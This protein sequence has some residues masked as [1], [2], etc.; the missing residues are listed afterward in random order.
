[1]KIVE[2][3]YISVFVASVGIIIAILTTNDVSVSGYTPQIIKNFGAVYALIL[4]TALTPPAD[5]L[6]R[7]CPSFNLIGVEC[8]VTWWGVAVI[9]AG[10]TSVAY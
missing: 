4:L 6:T 5:K 1:M 8:L 9:S 7:Y 2:I 3:I 10:G